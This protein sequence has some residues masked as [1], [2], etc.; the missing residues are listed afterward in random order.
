MAACPQLKVFL[1][2]A[3]EIMDLVVVDYGSGNLQSVSQALMA[4]S[5]HCDRDVTLNITSDPV[6]VSKADA[7]VL[8]GV[9]SFSDCVAGLDAI[10][11][12]K[13]ALDAA[14]R[15]DAK[16]FLGICVGMQLMV[17]LGLEGGSTPGLG[18]LKGKVSMITP[19]DPG[20]KI[21]HMGWNRLDI[22]SDHPLWANVDH[23]AAVYFLH[24]FAVSET[25]AMLA[26]TD[27]GG[28]VIAAIGRDNMIGLQFHPEKS[29]S[30]GQRILANWLNWKP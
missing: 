12:M 7:I 6:R 25:D 22:Q 13:M 23:D 26:Q 16:P 18:W 2:G 11:G 8:P 29:Q 20:L 3:S 24:S 5:R 1:A 4:A 14:V 30:V 9:G 19:D 21:P 17:E 28:P 27:Y 15:R 10:D